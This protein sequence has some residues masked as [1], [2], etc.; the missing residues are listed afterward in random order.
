MECYLVFKLMRI[1]SDSTI[2][3]FLI[4]WDLKI[5]LYSDDCL[6]KYVCIV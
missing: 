3:I 2:G 5:A 6:K 4:L 1:E